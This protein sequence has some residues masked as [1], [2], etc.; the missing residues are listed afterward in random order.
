[1]KGLLTMANA[2]HH[3]DFICSERQSLPCH[4]TADL[5]KLL[6]QSCL[7]SFHATIGHCLTQQL[8]ACNGVAILRFL[9]Q[10]DPRKLFA[11]ALI[12]I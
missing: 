11:Q 7:S 12:T 1:M 6:Q 8:Q 3:P 5:C 10:H 4:A 2:A 9:Y